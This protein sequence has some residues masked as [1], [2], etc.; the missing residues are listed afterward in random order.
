MLVHNFT[1][2][3]SSIIL[4]KWTVVKFFFFRAEP[5]KLRQLTMGMK[6]FNVEL[7]V[8]VKKHNRKFPFRPLTW[9]KNI[10]TVNQSITQ[11]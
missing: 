1:A 8:T 7:V 4:C 9:M 2:Q 6:L 5:I 3:N 10:F 11:D